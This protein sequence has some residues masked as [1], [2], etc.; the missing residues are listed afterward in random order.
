MA[1]SP[2]GARR[3]ST[4]RGVSSRA[5]CVVGHTM[6]VGYHLVLGD[7]ENTSYR[8]GWRH[9]SS[10]SATPIE[11]KSHTSR[12]SRRRTRKTLGF[13]SPEGQLLLRSRRHSYSPGRMMRN[14]PGRQVVSKRN[15]RPHI[16]LNSGTPGCRVPNSQQMRWHRGI[17]DRFR[18]S[19]R[20]RP[21]TRCL[22]RNRGDVSTRPEPDEQ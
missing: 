2:I 8:V 20:L 11:R 15:G 19:E 16:G 7:N 9:L 21:R 13:T 14:H 4:S 10:C 1:T 22:L 17:R 6:D 12:E 18:Q 5:K 3:C